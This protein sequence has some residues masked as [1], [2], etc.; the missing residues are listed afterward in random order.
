MS[1]TRRVFVSMP[2]E[3]HLSDEQNAFKWAVVKRLEQAGLFPEIFFNPHS[4]EGL[5]ASTTWTAERVDFV[6]RNCVGAVLIGLPRWTLEQKGSNVLMASEIHQYEGA[7]ARTLGLPLLT[8][9]Q[10]DVSK[11]GVFDTSFGTF[12][13]VFPGDH[14]AL[15]WLDSSIFAIALN[16]WKARIDDRR[17]IFIGY[18]SSS[19][20][21]AER[22]KSF[23]TD[24]GASVLD[25]RTDFS[26]GRSVLDEIS[27]ASRRCSAGIFLFTRDDAL[28]EGAVSVDKAI[29][30]DNVVFEAGYFM[31]LKGP[32]RVLIVRESG[33][34]MPADLGGQIYATVPDKSDISPIKSDLARFIT[35]LSSPRFPHEGY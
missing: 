6:L 25:W 35:Q 5:A 14:S 13:A 8:L 16:K 17:D 20:S 7:L 10:E 11:R 30:R 23:V 18:C 24:A 21:L 28:S 26:L 27:E 15:A 1:F 22:I 32:K 3:P 34:K 29:P 2:A 19:E 33:A 12:I 4:T 31:S 9:V